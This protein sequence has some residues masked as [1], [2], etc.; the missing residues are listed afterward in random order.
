MYCDYSRYLSIGGEMPEDQYFVWGE[1]ASRKIDQMTFGRA[2]K[3]AGI[4]QEELADAC[5]QMADVMARQWEFST[6]GADALQS[7]SNDGYSETY[8][9]PAEI[10]KESEKTLRRI[11]SDALGEDK[12]GLLYRGVC[13]CW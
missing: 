2:K 1:R 9:N 12:Y 7:A 6:S 13:E 3:Y 8:R 4:L 10:A 11:L 5:A